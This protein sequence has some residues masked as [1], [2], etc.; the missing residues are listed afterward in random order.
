[1]GYVTMWAYVWDFATVGM[2]KAVRELKDI[3]LDAVS[4]AAKYHTVEHL[5]TRSKT[6]KWFVARNAAFYFQP[7]TSLYRNTSI[8]PHTSPLLKD[9]DLF[10]QICDASNKLGLKVIA[11]T[12]F[13]HDSR[14][15]LSNPKA[16]MVNCFGDV[17]TSNL[18]PSNPQVR[19]FAKA[20]VKDLSRYP[21][22]AIECE[23]LHYGGIGHFHAHEKI[24]IQLGE[25]EQVLLGLCFC[26]SCQAFASERGLKLS[27]LKSQVA[28]WLEPVFQSGKPLSED[29]TD[30]LERNP[31]LKAFLE[32][33]KE[34][35]TSLVAEVSEDSNLPLSFILMGSEFETGASAAA[36]KTS[37]QRFEILA[38]TRNPREVRNRTRNALKVIGE[39]E[40]LVVGLQ[41]YQ[42][43]VTEKEILLALVEA[44]KGAGAKNLSFYHYGIM[45]PNHLDWVK[46]AIASWRR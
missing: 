34:V 41:A 23:S 11:W 35:V 42:P 17:Y 9:G 10:G 43:A 39:G 3:G 38:Y 24:G 46:E 27:T 6:Q 28:K 25:L 7:K 26:D 2:G 15:G 40:R 30:F 1:M 32:I 36:L 31:E 29:V 16:C 44:A 5:Q 8:K 19:E 18:C 22:M 13:L 20:L 12:V 45:P 33:R 4:V 37:V 21:L 14:A